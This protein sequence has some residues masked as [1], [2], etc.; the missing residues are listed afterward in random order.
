MEYNKLHVLGKVYFRHGLITN[1]GL[2]IGKQRRILTLFEQDFSS[3]FKIEDLGPAF[4][5]LGCNIIRNRSCGTLHLV[6]TQYLKGVLQ[7][8]GMSEC[9]PV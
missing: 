2:L 6:Q 3:R 9:T 5:I 1:N 8:F 4:W 7:E